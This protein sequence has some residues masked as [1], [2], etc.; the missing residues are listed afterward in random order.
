[1][2]LSISNQPIQ[3]M[4]K[5]YSNKQSKKEQLKRF[6]KRIISPVMNVRQRDNPRSLEGNWSIGIYVGTSPSDFMPLAGVQNPV[7]TREDVSDIRAAFVADPFML[8]VNHMWY[9][10]FEVMNQ[11]TNKG[12]IGFAVSKDG[13]KW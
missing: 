2:Y 7:L 4:N 10:F 8:R 12:E 9:M 6:I 13:L 11:K 5:N 1:M 3:I